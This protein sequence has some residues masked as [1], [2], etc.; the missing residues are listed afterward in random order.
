MTAQDFNSTNLNVFLNHI[1]ELRKGIRKM[2]LFTTARMNEN[3]AVSRLREQGIEYFIQYADPNVNIYFGAAE[4]MAAVKIFADKPL[5]RLSPEED[6]MLGA[7]LG[8]DISVQCRRYCSRKVSCFD[9][10]K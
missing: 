7:M 3:Y 6:F 1:Y 4:C 9:L 10:T 5:N 8:Y 2:A